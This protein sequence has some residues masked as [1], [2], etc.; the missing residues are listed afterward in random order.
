MNISIQTKLI[1]SFLFLFLFIQQ[2]YPQEN[3]GIIIRVKATP[4]KDIMKMVEKQTGYSFTYN[5]TV[6]LSQKKSVDIK[7]SK[8]TEVL[9]A[10]FKETSI[11]WKLEGQHI[12]LKN[13]KIEKKPRNVTISGYVTDI[14]SSETLIGASVVNSNSGYGSFANSYGYYTIQVPAGTIK[15]KASYTGYTPIEK[16][17]CINKD[18]VI[19]FNLKTGI[20]LETIT[21]TNTSTFSP[22]GSSIELTQDQIKSMPA[23]LG[24]ADVLKSLQFIPGVQSGAEGSAGMYVR[25]GNID[26]N[27]TLLDGIP[28]YNTGHF[29]GIVSIFNGDAVKKVSLH[30]GSFPARFGGRLSSVVDIRLKDGDMQNYHG[31]FNI[32]ILSGRINFEG[33]IIRGKTSFNLS[34]RRS[35]ADV[36]LRA[37]KLFTDESVPILYMYDLNAKV[38]HKFSDRSRLYLSLYNGKDKEGAVSKQDESNFYSKSEIDYKWGN[39]VAAL[40]WNYIFSNKLFA[41]TTVAYNRYNFDFRSSEELKE[42]DF[43]S[44]Y[45]NF[46]N[47]EIKDISINADL[48]YI[49]DNRHQIKFGSGFTFHRFNP[50]IHGSKIKEIENGEE[51]IN[52]SNH[53]LNSRIIGRESLVYIEDEFSV[54]NRFKANLGLHFSLFNVQQ[55][56]YTSLQPRIS[57][58]Y[59]FNSHM[60]IKASYTKMN[61]YINLLTSNSLVQPTDL[62]VPITN[63]LKPMVA[64]QYTLGVYYDKGDGYSLSA[65]TFYK[66]MKNVLEYK[67]GASWKDTYKSWEEQVEPGKGWAYGIE[68]FGQKTIGK[69][70]GMAGYTLAWNERKFETINE[71]RRFAAKYDQRH[72]ISLT[73]TYKPG[74]KIELSASWMYATGNNATLALEEFQPL[75]DVNVPNGQIIHPLPTIEQVDKR[76]NYRL[77]ANHHLDLNLNY[78]RS[79]RK[80][81]SF[82]IYNVYN[83][84][85]PF[86][87]YPGYSERNGQVGKYNLFRYSIFRFVPSISYT[88]KF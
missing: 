52:K 33:P 11:E 42:M 63:R 57:L 70:T 60:A 26:Q 64:H 30:K 15:L 13:R 66:R 74:D 53:F 82:T 32:G 50:E 44:Y 68:L 17:A 38:N 39:T 75:P 21:I 10:T 47:S 27:L 23:V 81:W 76:N 84:A 6:D 55:K 8:L 35:Y 51:S 48:E 69:Y 36:F 9:H 78:H 59:E 40:R 5:E 85:N 61:Q 18:T 41:N 77:P 65:E 16:N 31:S 34:A 73:M 14:E 49:P 54:F 20:E 67:D 37:A 28:I 29:Y 80:M 24:E 3:T 45:E 87:V 71:G 22:S 79:K 1:Y 4:L 25:G 43:N 19:N 56:T 62:W 58:G 72:N 7:S 88:Y 46:Q 86:M 2:A 83:R 12:I